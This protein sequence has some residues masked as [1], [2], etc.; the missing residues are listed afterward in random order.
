MNQSQSQ[1]LH[2]G[3]RPLT[4]AHLAQTMTLLELSSVELEQ[5]IEAELAA[6]PALELQEQA[7]CPQC[8][9]RLPPSRICP[10][11]SRPA[12][13]VDEQPI[14][15][16]SP[17]TDFA[18]Y[19]YRGASSSHSSDDMAG[20]EWAAE[21]EDLPTYILR[22]IAPE[23]DKE[24]RILAAHIL[25]SLD[26]DGLLNVPLSEIA[27]YHRVRMARLENILSLIQHADPP[28]VGSPTPQQALL[29]QLEILEETGDV[30]PLAAAAIQKGMDLLSR[31]AYME[32]GKRLKVS[33]AEAQEI[34]RFISENLNPYPA[35]AHWGSVRHS[36]HAQPNYP[37][38]DVM[39]SRLTNEPTTPL[40]V[41]VISPYAGMLRVNP[42]FRQSLAQASDSTAEKWQNDLDSAV[43]LVKCLQQRDHTLVRLMQ[44]LVVIQRQFILKGDA[45]L[46]PVTRASLAETLSVHEST[47]S[48]A[49]SS[50][51]ILL[52]NGRII[53]M[54]RMFDR[55]L[56]VR[57]AL[58]CIVAAERRPLSDTQ[59]ARLLGD[60]GYDVARR[61]VA[62][63][64]NM[65]GILPARL[66]AA[67]MKA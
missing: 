47:V 20:E 45:F 62:K 65:E 6:N 46:L 42:L 48:R 22:Q 51:S 9:R 58:R 19:D 23:L 60:Q 36:T 26:D 17:R 1:V 52:P 38:P 5:K 29:V 8:H 2:H 18:T 31:H 37:S 16:V 15:F 56:H 53:P 61:T 21:A 40:V 63:Y 30:P 10:V 49:V 12:S 50:K 28:G 64:R 39:I 3:L 13:A 33:A 14:I 34:A 4:T 25:T 55:S 59:I 57:T 66:R 11:C 41:E 44:Q 7:H 43:L 24:D 32:L 35:R 27:L 54:S 67:S